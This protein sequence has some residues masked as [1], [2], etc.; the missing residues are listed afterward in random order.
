MKL[1][2]RRPLLAL[3]AMTAALTL[4]SC[5]PLDKDSGKPLDEDAKT[6]ESPL[7]KLSDDKQKVA[8]LIGL[9]IG[10]SIQPIKD[11]IEFQTLIRSIRESMEGNAPEIDY[12]E[13]MAV[14]Q[15]LNERMQAKQEAAAEEQKAN[16]EE[17]AQKNLEEGRAFLEE[18]ANK[19]GITTTASGLQYEVIK[20]GEGKKPGASDLVH[21]HYEGTLL[22]GEVFDSSYARNEP[23]Q[24]PVN[25]VISGWTEAL[26]LMPEG[27]K[28]RL[29]IPADI[30]YGETG[31]GPI[32]PNA[33][34]AFE[35][36]LLE[37]VKAP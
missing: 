11:E 34:L 10:E 9:Q 36:E 8:Y 3:L 30:A 25:G 14:M 5:K 32:G 13:A 1:S 2:L 20:Q 26:Q 18:N 24:F 33:T 27:S 16:N 19:P 31:N 29:W 7:A 15:G 35:V 23:V 21:V 17:M 6:T 22:N 4:I 37:V 28:Y 12:A